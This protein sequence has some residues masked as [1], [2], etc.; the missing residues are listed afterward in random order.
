MSQTKEV[1]KDEAAASDVPTSTDP[2]KPVHALRLKADQTVVDLSAEPP[3]EE[4]FKGDPKAALAREAL[5]VRLD[6]LQERLYAEGR[7]KLLVVMQAMDTGGKDGTIRKVFARTNIMGLHVAR[8]QAPT[9]TELARDYLWRVHAEVP[10]QGQIGVFNRSHYEDVLTVRVNEL[11]PEAVWR[12][13]YGHL[14][15]FERLL[16]DE[17]T[18]IVKLF[19]HIGRDEQRARLQA[20][21]DEP[22]KRWKFE[23]ND[24]IQ[25]R[26][27]DAY[28]QAYTDCIHETDKDHAPWYVIPANKKWY[29]DL[30]V[31][32]VLVATLEAMD[33]QYPAPRFDPAETRLDP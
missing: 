15:D 31:L 5:T 14:R 20:R 28:M 3:D 1:R 21:L 7:R 6:G 29:R 30:A 23:P 16:A 10:A 12:R 17:G 25:R 24:I 11:V 32:D 9:S 8:F 13:R 22:D 18:R 26:H 2:L 4:R 27:W 33:P 19:L